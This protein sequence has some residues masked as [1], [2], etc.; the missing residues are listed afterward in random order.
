MS[1]KL[2]TWWNTSKAKENGENLTTA[3]S[4]NQEVGSKR[5]RK[6]K[7]NLGCSAREHCGD[8]RTTGRRRGGRRIGPG[9]RRGGRAQGK[10]PPRRSPAHPSPRR[11][12]P[13]CPRSR[14]D[15]SS[16]AS[17]PP[18]SCSRLQGE[19]RKRCAVSAGIRSR[20]SLPI[21][22]LFSAWLNFNGDD[23][24]SHLYVQ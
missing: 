3:I 14:S 4:T 5:E 24:W 22:S 12:S 10:G 7:L 13:R 8:R 11:Y 19:G 9:R 6:K 2:A 16:L 15:A 20:V 17:A 1:I 21:Y 23:V 18:L